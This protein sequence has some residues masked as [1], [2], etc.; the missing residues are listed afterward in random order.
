MHI[1]H[2]LFDI[3]WES[4][5]ID[6]GTHVNTKCV[7]YFRPDT[8][9]LLCSRNMWTHELDFH[10]PPAQHDFSLSDTSP[11]K[12]QCAVIIGERMETTVGVMIYGFV[13]NIRHPYVI[14]AIKTSIASKLWTSIRIP[15]NHGI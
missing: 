7:L 6:R 3:I 2:H 11:R 4:A 1:I 12:F 15:I 5:K 10:N 13:L 9:T 14:I 8:H